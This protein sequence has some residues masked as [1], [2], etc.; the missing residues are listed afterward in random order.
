MLEKGSYII[1]RPIPEEK[2][3]PPKGE[4]IPPTENTKYLVGKGVTSVLGTHID[5]LS[6]NTSQLLPDWEIRRKGAS[7]SFTFKPGGNTVALWPS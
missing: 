4:I 6:T 3:S 7:K 2:K 1:A 5:A